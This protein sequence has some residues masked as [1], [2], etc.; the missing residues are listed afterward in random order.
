MNEIHQLSFEQLR[1]VVVVY[2][3][4]LLPLLLI[5]YLSWRRKI[6]TWSFKVYIA[7]FIICALGWELWFTYGLWAGDPVDIRR[8][9]V[10][11]Y[12]IPL[13]LNWLLNSLADAGSICMMGIFYVWLFHRKNLD[14][15]RSWHWSV[16]FTFLIYFIGQNIIVEM[17]L[18]HD[19]LSVDKAL[20]WAPLAPTGPWVNPILFEFNG[21][22][23]TLQGQLP[24]L[25]LSPIFYLGL[26][27]TLRK[28][29]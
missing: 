28:V 24:W 15:L 2:T 3:S 4:A 11:N 25:I 13:H 29:E 9:T 18:Y 21:R 7:S 12:Y 20:S 23:I 17:F 5:P 6:P 19:Q 8:A 10:L 22:T 16:F 27:S 14:V 1:L 26:I